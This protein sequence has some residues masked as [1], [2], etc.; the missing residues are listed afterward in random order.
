[1]VSRRRTR[2]SRRPTGPR[3]RYMWEI[4]GVDPAAQGQNV[5]ISTNLTGALDDTVRRFCTVVRIVGT[6]MVTFDTSDLQGAC[7]MGVYRTSLEA[8][9]AGARP[10]FELD[11]WPVLYMDTIYG[12]FGDLAAGENKSIQHT[13]DIR[14]RRRLRADEIIV[15]QRENISRDAVTLTTAFNARMLLRVN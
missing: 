7:Q 15:L 3:P 8:F 2:S 9:N 5:A 6:W 14:A 12:S 11:L 4:V 13:L 10:E 1:M